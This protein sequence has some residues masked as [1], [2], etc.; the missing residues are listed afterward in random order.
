M[1]IYYQLKNLVEEAKMRLSNEEETI[2]E[3][4]KFYNEKNL[5]IE[6]TKQKFENLIKEL[7]NI[8]INKLNDFINE[9][10]I[11]I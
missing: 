2:I 10:K 9:K 11:I 1:I 7:I 5:F 4:E 3:Q 6:I 8:L